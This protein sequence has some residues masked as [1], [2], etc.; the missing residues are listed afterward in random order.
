M[1]TREQRKLKTPESWHHCPK[2]HRKL[3]VSHF[4]HIFPKYS[5][6]PTPDVLTQVCF[7][8]Q[9]HCPPGF[10]PVTVPSLKHK[11]AMSGKKKSPLDIPVA[12]SSC[13]WHW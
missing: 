1:K 7:S 8:Q 5:P 3:N 12:T 2:C 10:P 6:S 9:C 13:I 11:H 4:P